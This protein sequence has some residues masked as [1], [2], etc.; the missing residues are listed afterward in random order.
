[1]NKNT[2]ILYGGKSALIKNEQIKKKIRI[3]DEIREAD[4]ILYGFFFQGHFCIFF[5]SFPDHPLF[6]P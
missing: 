6:K 3:G 4:V 1:M 2:T 5:F